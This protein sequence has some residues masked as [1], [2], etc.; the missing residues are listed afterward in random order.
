ME[1]HISKG[2]H[3][4]EIR[5]R[6]PA[7]PEEVQSALSELEQYSEPAKITNVEHPIERLLGYI[8]NADLSSETDI[9]DLN[10][11]AERVNSMNQQEQRIFVGA[12]DA[13]SINGL[14]DVC[15]VAESLDQYEF[16]AGVNT[17]R[18]LGGWLVEHDR[19][20]V[21]FPEEVRPY[22]DYIAIG[23][24]YYANHGGAYTP[25]GYVKHREN[26]LDLAEE[27]SILHLVLA[28]SEGERSLGLPVSDER[29]EQ[30]KAR[31]GLDDFA[32][33]QVVRIETEQAA[34]ALAPLLPLDHITIEDANELALCLQEMEQE[35]GALMK[36][37]AVLEVEQPGIFTEALNIAMDRD[38]YELVPEDMEEYGQQV[39]RRAGADDEIIDTID[40]YMD[41]AQL[42]MDSLGADGVRRTEFGLV[43]RLS[44][45]FPEQQETGQQMM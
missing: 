3:D 2:N 29:M 6:F 42:G 37:C 9:Q 44:M 18:E 10:A 34:S 13:E 32:Q 35:A 5:L 17:D 1:L 16:I 43:R 36:F 28:T 11:L 14:K 23:A 21:A 41:F 25:D 4:S 24:E 38:D 40:G 26:V 31:L 8:R 45:P 33:V 27:K 22:L 7:S 15:R 30:V 19:L 12:L 39:L 20:G